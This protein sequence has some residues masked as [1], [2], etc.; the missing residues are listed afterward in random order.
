M[1]EL[2]RI[3]QA[4]RNNVL[5]FQNINDGAG[6]MEGTLLHRVAV[7][8]N[9]AICEYLLK[10]GA[11]ASTVDEYGAI[12]LH[13]ACISGDQACV[14]ILLKAYPSGVT[15]RDT[16]GFTSLHY[17]C[18]SNSN[19]TNVICAMLI[20]AGSPVDA[21]SGHGKTP[22]SYAIGNSKKDIVR[23][24]I[25]HGAKVANVFV[26]GWFV[27]K[28]PQWVVVFVERREAVRS[29]AAAWIFVVRFS[30]PCIHRIIGKDMIRLVAGEI[31]AAR[32]NKIF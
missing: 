8:G 21:F 22:L 19:A 27:K 15:L 20:D 3:K 16:T 9:F 13:K 25:D 18:F 17:A 12:P 1:S 6:G 7:N 4:L 23:L 31:W 29:S 30:Q 28:I 24:L 5:T 2:E 10:I 11:D 26:D 32:V 14:A